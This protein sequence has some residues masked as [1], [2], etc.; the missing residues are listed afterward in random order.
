VQA[1]AH[2][3]NLAEVSAPARWRPRTARSAIRN[4]C[5]GSNFGQRSVIYGRTNPMSSPLT[6]V[7]PMGSCSGLAPPTLT[8]SSLSFHNAIAL[9][10]TA[11]WRTHATRDLSRSEWRRLSLIGSVS[12]ASWV[13]AISAGRMIGYG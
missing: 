3:A 9:R 2:D 5:A 11:A 4:L 6:V 10:F 7:G 13:T 1:P 8:N 12:L